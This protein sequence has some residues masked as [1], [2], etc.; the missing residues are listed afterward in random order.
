MLRRIVMTLT[1][2]SMCVALAHRAR[3]EDVKIVK[4]G[5]VAPLSGFSASYG[6][7]E[8]NAARLAFEEANAQG[9]VIGGQKIRFEVDGQDDAGDPKTA[10]L[11]AQR[12]VDEGVS[13]VIGHHNSGCSIAA[14]AVYRRAGIPQ[15][16]PASSSPSYTAQG[17]ETTFRT[18]SNDDQMAVLAA[19]YSVRQLGAKR[20]AVIDD[21]T[22]YGTNLATEYVKAVQ[23]AGAKLAS[24]QYTTTKS[25]DFRAV[26]TTIKGL[27]PDLIFY[28]GQDIQAAGVAKQIHQLGIKAKYM[29]E[30][31]FTN[32][33]FLHLVG[34]SG[35]GMYSWE[36][37]APLGRMPRAAE[38]DATMKARFGTGIV[39]FAP[40]AYDAAWAMMNAMKKADSTDPR[41]YLS[42]L[43]AISFDGVTGTIAFN[44]QGDLKT[45]S[46]TLYQ[47]QNGKWVVLGVEQTSPK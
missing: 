17:F 42:S 33:T 8:E 22:D 47:Q 27:N 3:A 39:Q 44:E 26:L 31:G 9:L 10:V 14:S 7:D 40:L 21:S 20:V 23:N 46:A 15:I 35:Q 25:I 43:H 37:G 13:G 11:V 6:K 30:G 4:I 18:I 41:T 12:F 5:V 19:N 38:L 45:A 28:V 1:L 36:Y 24:W 32:D 2:L 16:S 29:G 34:Q